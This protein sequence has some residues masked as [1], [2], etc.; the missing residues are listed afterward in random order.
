VVHGEAGVSCA[1]GDEQIAS[2]RGSRGSWRRRRE[3]ERAA[4]ELVGAGWEARMKTLQ[5][6]VEATG[7]GEER[8]VSRRAWRWGAAP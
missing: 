4:E 2:R 6:Q 7:P 5:G 3:I 8:R 1:L